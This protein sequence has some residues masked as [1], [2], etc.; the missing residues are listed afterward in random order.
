VTGDVVNI[1]SR[2][3]G[4]APAG[5]VVVGVLTYRATRM[6]IEYEE[7]DP[8]RGEGKDGP[9]P[10]WRSV[11]ARSRFGVDVEQGTR[12]PLI[13]REHELSLL[14]DLFRRAMRE[15]NPQLVTL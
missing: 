15:Q 8:V 4:L 3:Q 5:G 13:G 12:T 9:I 6:A 2:L 11:A 1:A 7:I 14:K 10:I